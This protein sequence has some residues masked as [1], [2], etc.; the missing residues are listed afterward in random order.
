M[1]TRKNDGALVCPLCSSDVSF[2]VITLTVRSRTWR[3]THAMRFKPDRPDPKKFLFDVPLFLT[4]CQCGQALPIP[5]ALL[6]TI[7]AGRR[8]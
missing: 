3:Q 7:N 5:P 1:P 2:N 4:C 8:R 6:K